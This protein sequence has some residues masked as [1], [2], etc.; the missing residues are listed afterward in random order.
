MKIFDVVLEVGVFLVGFI[1]HRAVTRISEPHLDEHSMPDA[2]TVCRSN[3][4]G[5][6]LLPRH[7]D[8]RPV[9]VPSSTLR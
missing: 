7:F 6:T 9:S 1:K 3:Q 4:G 5:F 2:R 8:H